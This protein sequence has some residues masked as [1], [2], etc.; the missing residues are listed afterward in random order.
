MPAGRLR[1]RVTIQQE[2]QAN[3]SMGGG[4]RGWADVATVWASVE[5]LRGM[6][7]LQA[8]QLEISVSH[9]VIM[10]Y[11]PGVTAKNR[12]LWGDIALNIREATNPDR[13]KMFLQLICDQGV[14]S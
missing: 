8:M 12:L 4:A 5:P 1:E 6:E 3:D 10:R 14:V 2:S 9:K 11:R 13:K 7:Q